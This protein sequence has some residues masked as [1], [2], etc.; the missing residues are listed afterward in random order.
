MQY[1]CCIL[2]VWCVCVS[3]VCVRTTASPHLRVRENPIGKVLCLF[4]CS[5]LQQ[6]AGE[7]YQGNL[8]MSFMA[9]Q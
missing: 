6:L 4:I 2:H 8:F 9:T 5:C 3:Y 7:V 1:M